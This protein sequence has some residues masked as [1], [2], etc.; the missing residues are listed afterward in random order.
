MN[1][2]VIL[3]TNFL[4]SNTGKIKEIVSLIEAKG[5]L[6]YIP[7]M[8]QEEYINIQLRKVKEQYKKI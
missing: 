7:Q 8:V 5:N 2:I 4:V 1:K 3:D 6:V